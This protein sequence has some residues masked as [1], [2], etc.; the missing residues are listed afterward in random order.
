MT[1]IGSRCWLLLLIQVKV[2]GGLFLQN[3]VTIISSAHI[4]HLYLCFTPSK[5]NSNFRK[6]YQ[7]TCSENHLVLLFGDPDLFIVPLFY[8][9]LGIVQCHSLISNKSFYQKFI[10][11]HFSSVH[12]ANGIICKGLMLPGVQECPKETETTKE[13][14]SL[15]TNPSLPRQFVNWSETTPQQ[16]YSQ[17]PVT[18]VSSSFS[19]NEVSVLMIG[20]II[21]NL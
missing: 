16:T 11:S 9:R 17:D 18:S 2:D 14:S 12:R 5:P 13:S 8:N 21:C 3:Y 10:F 4:Q 7:S 19:V 20:L 6:N 1:K 15:S